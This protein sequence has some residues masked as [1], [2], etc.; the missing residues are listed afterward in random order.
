[1]MRKPMK[2]NS[3]ADDGYSHFDS[4]VISVEHDVMT[5][6]WDQY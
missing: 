3:H 4:S 6:T 1:L 2:Y 5:T